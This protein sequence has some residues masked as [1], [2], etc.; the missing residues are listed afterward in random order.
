MSVLRN[1]FGPS[2][3]EIWQQLCHEIGADFIEGGFW[4][5]SKVQVHVKSWTITLD[6]FSV[7][8]SNASSGTASTTT[9]TRMR[10]PYINKD[11]FQFKIYQQGLFSKL[12]KLFG[13]RDIEVGYPEFD[14]RYII[15]GNDTYKV[16]LLFANPTI[17]QLIQA[18]PSINLEVKDDEGWF[19]TSF[20]EGV[21][22]LYFEVVGDIKEVERL[23]LLYELFAETLNYLCHIGSAYEEDPGLELK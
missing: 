16:Q 14:D 15:Q 2:K 8:N 23:K 21:D 12:G 18:Q 4:K 7:S 20:P 13:M 6:T 9:Y 17:R 19:G 11:G 1:L 3:D 10:A 5:G 22:E